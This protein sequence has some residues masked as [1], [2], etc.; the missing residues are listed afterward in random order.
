MTSK[1]MNDIPMGRM[2]SMEGSLISE[3]SVKLLI[4]PTKKL[5]YLKKPKIIRSKTMLAT[6][7][8]FFPART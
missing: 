3:L 1:V 7:H 2:M 4:E 6:S 8:L 5:K